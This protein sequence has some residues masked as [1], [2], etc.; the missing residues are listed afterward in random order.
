MTDD[1]SKRVDMTFE[2]GQGD[3]AGPRGGDRVERGGLALP[4]YDGPEVEIAFDPQ[5]LVEILRALEGE[6][7]VTL[8]MSGRPEAGAVPVRRRVRVPGDA[9]GGVIPVPLSAAGRA[10]TDGDP[11]ADGNPVPENLA[12]ILGRL[13]TSPRVGAEERPGAAG[14]AWAEAAGRRW[15]KDTRVRA[16]AAGCWRSR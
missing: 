16:S 11:M 13:F 12:D 7:T 10:E 2:A 1:E 8:E 9:A 15:L 14:A 4:E 6:P 3:D 5:Y